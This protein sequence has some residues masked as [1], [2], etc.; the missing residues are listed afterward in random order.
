MTD[1]MVWK[2]EQWFA[3]QMQERKLFFTEVQA[4]EFASKL[5]GVA[6]DLVLTIEPMP[7]QH[8]WN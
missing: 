7:I 2:C 6:P 1:T 3:G 5:N 8:V 4:R